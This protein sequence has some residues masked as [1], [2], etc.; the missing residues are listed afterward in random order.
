MRQLL[1]LTLA[2]G[3]AG[4]APNLAAEFAGDWT[5]ASGQVTETCDA[6]V[7]RRPLKAG[8]LRLTA[9][10]TGPSDL[11]LTWRAF[12]EGR[13]IGTCEQSATVEEAGVASLESK[14]CTFGSYF[15]ITRGV[16]NLT[17]NKALMLHWIAGVSG[18][19]TPCEQDW[20]A[21]LVA[22]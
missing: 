19:T 7:L 13:E 20:E 8:T 16:L 21:V 14:G 3:L 4:C 11:R 6:G 10:G 15:P 5:L 1:Q 12:D 9:A 22:D 18:M 17:A 2:A